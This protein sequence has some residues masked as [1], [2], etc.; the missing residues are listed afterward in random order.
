MLEEGVAGCTR[1]RVDRLLFAHDEFEE[2]VA[3]VNPV[4]SLRGCRL[5]LKERGIGRGRQERLVRLRLLLLLEKLLQVVGDLSDLKLFPQRLQ[6]LQLQLLL[7]LLT[8]LLC[9]L[10]LGLRE[11]FVDEEAASVGYLRGRC[12][13]VQA[14]DRRL[15]L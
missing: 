10:Q 12:M 3:A 4:E 2:T 15:L 7:L 1:Q 11:E 14:L 5:G 8:L 6:L 13:L 9:C